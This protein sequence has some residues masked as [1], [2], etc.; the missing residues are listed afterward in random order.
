MRVA[1]DRI[2]TRRIVIAHTDGCALIAQGL[3]GG[4][5]E[6]V[7]TE[8]RFGMSVDD[9]RMYVFGPVGSGRNNNC[10]L[11]SFR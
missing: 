9:M 10:Y 6:R 3:A 1:L 2:E 5:G 4:P 8:C 7:I 11:I